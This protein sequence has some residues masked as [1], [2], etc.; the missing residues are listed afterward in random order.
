MHQYFRASAAAAVLGLTCAGAV[1]AAGGPFKIGYLDLDKVKRDY[2]DAARA[3]MIK[4]Q[5]ESQLRDVID[6]VNRDLSAAVKEG[7][8]PEELAKMK[9]QYQLQINGMQEGMRAVVMA[10]TLDVSNKIMFATT[11][12]AKEK[13][14]EMVVDR[15]NV[16]AG[17]DKLVSCEDLTDPILKR[18]NAPRAASTP[19]PGAP[20]AAKPATP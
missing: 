17:A 8:K 12:V 19:A 11:E 15:N 10:Q 1:L 20:A 2:P 6:K 14:L 18:L 7:K 9:E 16:F 5:V 4:L 13:S 3:E